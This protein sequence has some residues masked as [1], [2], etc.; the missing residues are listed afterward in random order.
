MKTIISL[1]MICAALWI[2]LIG[3]GDSGGKDDE[4]TTV[5]VATPAFT[6]S[7]ADDLKTPFLCNGGTVTFEIK[8]TGTCAYR[9]DLI[10]KD[11]Q[12]VQFNLGT[13][14][15]DL[16][17]KI[18]KALDKGDYL[19]GV[20]TTCTWS[21]G[22]YGPVVQY[23]TSSATTSS[24]TGSTTS[25]STSSTTTYSPNGNCGGCCSGHGGVICNGGSASCGDGTLLSSTCQSK[26][27][28]C[29]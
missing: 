5:S 27:C 22:I 2:G 4:D 28:A 7:K 26:G 16:D 9:F 14:S 25:T 21:V 3:C 19:L 20:S 13:G 24:T 29:Q 18:D 6:Y 23:A 11:T 17:V 15:G 8:H 1:T 10:N 12:K